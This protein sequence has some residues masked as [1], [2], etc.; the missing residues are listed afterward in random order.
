MGNTCART[1]DL[2]FKVDL[3][4]FLRNLLPR[5]LLNPYI[6]ELFFNTINSVLDIGIVIEMIDKII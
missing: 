1:F 3:E 4:M 6:K 5:I 2:Y